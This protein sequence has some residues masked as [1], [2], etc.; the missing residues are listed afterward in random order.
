MLSP[1]PCWEHNS[2]L[3]RSHNKQ[4]YGN[5][6]GET[7]R[8]SVLTQRTDKLMVPTASDGYQKKKKT[9]SMST[10]PDIQTSVPIRLARWSRFECGCEL[11][12]RRTWKQ[13]KKKMQPQEGRT[14][15]KFTKYKINGHPVA[16]LLSDIYYTV[17][18][19]ACIVIAW[20]KLKTEA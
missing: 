9:E 19:H 4:W 18:P 7:N 11:E 12:S 15:R 6:I 20:T 1:Y 14:K 3:G 5:L 10:Q 17:V 13:T 8:P 2:W 16:V